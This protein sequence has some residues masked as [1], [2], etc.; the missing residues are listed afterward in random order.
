MC[1][2]ARHWYTSKQP[3]SSSS[4]SKL[5]RGPLGAFVCALL[6]LCRFSLGTSCAGAAANTAKA[7]SDAAALTVSALTSPDL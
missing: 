5:N 6:F 3:N 7:E 4:N 1:A 2:F